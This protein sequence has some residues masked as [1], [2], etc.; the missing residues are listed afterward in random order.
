MK[1]TLCLLTVIL[2]GSIASFAQTLN[3]AGEKF[4]QGNENYKAK[5][6]A[7]AITSYT[8]ALS[9]CEQLGEEASALTPKIQKMIPQ[10]KVQYAKALVGANNTDE[11][12]TILEEASKEAE[13]LGED[14]L[15]KSADNLVA[16][17]YVAYAGAAYGEKNW[18]K[19]IEN[20][21]KAITMNKSSQKAYLYKALSYSEM[22]DADAMTAAAEMAIK[23]ADAHNDDKTSSTA[24]QVA[25]TFF[26]NK[27]QKLIADKKYEDA[28]TSL[29]NAISFSPSSEAT[30][31]YKASCLNKLSRYDDAITTSLLA[32]TTES[33]SSEIRNGINLELARA[34]EAKGDTANACTY[35][36]LAANSATFKEEA[37]QKMKDVLKCN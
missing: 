24:K 11:A 27:A 21:D 8:E 7:E 5:N 37:T 32:L 25:G 3:D 12:L 26:V 15:K 34:Y 2:W 22:E 1:K 36:A 35:Y 23:I 20:C 17:I 14:K 4:N 29:D 33:E 28:I 9:I 31:Y 16:N 10:S 19:V 13:T 30:L 18:D 6:Y